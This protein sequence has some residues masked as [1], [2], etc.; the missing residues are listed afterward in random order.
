MRNPVLWFH[1]YTSKET[2]PNCSLARE[3]KL[4][5]NKKRCIKQISKLKTF[6]T[7]LLKPLWWL[8]TLTER[9]IQIPEINCFV[10]VIL[11]D[12]IISFLFV[13]MFKRISMDGWGLYPSLGNLQCNCIR[14]HLVTFMST[15]GFWPDKAGCSALART[16]RPSVH[17]GLTPS[18]MVK[19]RSRDEPCLYLSKCWG[20]L[21][22]RISSN[23]RK[24][25]GIYKMD[26]DDLIYKT[27]HLF[28]PSEEWTCCEF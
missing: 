28:L 4:K 24:R 19:H 23:S 5:I 18:S 1:K 11:W 10:L 14:K 21:F 8:M 27:Y 17:W 6:K 12:F 3:K 7:L 2:T 15:L 20:N 25:N 16:S 26:M 22:Q 13:R 9:V